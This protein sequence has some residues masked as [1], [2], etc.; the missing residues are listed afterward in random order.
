MK[1]I[2]ALVAYFFIFSPLFAGY[3]V[4]LEDNTLDPRKGK[5]IINMFVINETDT[6]KAININPKFRFITDDEEEI[7]QDTEDLLI[8]PSQLIL[9][10]KSEKAVS[11]RWTGSKDIPHELSYRAIVEELNVGKKIEKDSKTIRTKLKYVKSVYIAPFKEIKSITLEK[12]EQTINPETSEK[13]LEFT[14]FNNGTVR[15]YLENLMFEYVIPPNKIGT[16][17]INMTDVDLQ[18]KS[19]NLLSK[20]KLKGIIK[21]PESIPEDVKKFS[22]TYYNLES[23]EE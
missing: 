23:D 7:L 15:E 18:D 22:L 19:P 10:A 2:Y 16:I 8:F 13:M 5:N 4:V 17:L 14:L 21:W 1:M 3:Q 6:F 20:R 9:P 12:T 11:I